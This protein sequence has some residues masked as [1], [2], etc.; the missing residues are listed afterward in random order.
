MKAKK[1]EG[2][3][4]F[5]EKVFYSTHEHLQSGCFDH[6]DYYD[7]FISYEVLR[8]SGR[9]LRPSAAICGGL[10]FC[11]FGQLEYRTLHRKL[12]HIPD[13]VVKDLDKDK[14][15][16]PCYRGTMSTLLRHLD[17]LRPVVLSSKSSDGSINANFLC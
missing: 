15:V 17:V 13:T 7:T 1:P 16:Y 11:C 2:A 10:M 6:Q 5:N 14:V 12:I 8:L 9:A 4:N 3:M